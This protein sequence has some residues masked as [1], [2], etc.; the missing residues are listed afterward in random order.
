MIRGS[1]ASRPAQA[2]SLPELRLAA[3]LPKDKIKFGQAVRH[4]TIAK[5]LCF[6]H[7]SNRCPAD[8]CAAT[9]APAPPGSDPVPTHTT[10]IM[11]RTTRPALN[12]QHLGT[13]A[14]VSGDDT[15]D[16]SASSSTMADVA[17]PTAAAIPPL[18]RSGAG[19]SPSG[20]LP[21]SPVRAASPVSVPSRSAS[22]A[23]GA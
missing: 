10:A 21:V 3:Q 6:S 15:N 18:R 20:Q 14:P 16:S 8:Q 22:T 19:T 11:H 13:T 2:Y 4:A 5:E 12:K 9:A 17:T 23:A 7:T 1:P